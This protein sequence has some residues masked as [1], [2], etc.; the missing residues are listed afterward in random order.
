MSTILLEIFPQAGNLLDGTT[1]VAASAFTYA[2]VADSH[3]TAEVFDG[4]SDVGVVDLRE[5]LAAIEDQFGNV[6]DLAAVEA[7]NVERVTDLVVERGLILAANQQTVEVGVHS[8]PLPGA[9]AGIRDQLTPN[10]FGTV[11]SGDLFRFG[12]SQFVSTAATGVRGG[13]VT[14]PTAYRFFFESDGDSN[15][16]RILLWLL[17]LYSCACWGAFGSTNEQGPVP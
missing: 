11:G 10:T 9:T 15:P 3:Y 8:P 1:F 13:V 6:I 2:R 17:P 14:V 4:A 7:Q 5:M 12:G 16:P